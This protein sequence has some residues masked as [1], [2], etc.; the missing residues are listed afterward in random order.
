MFILCQPEESEFYHD[1]LIKIEEDLFSSLGLH[2]KY[3]VSTAFIDLYV[4]C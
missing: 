2:Y 1:E 3:G 4:G